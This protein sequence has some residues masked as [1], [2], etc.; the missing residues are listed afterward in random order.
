MQGCVE[1]SHSSFSIVPVYL[2]LTPCMM[3]SFL[4]TRPQEA[5]FVLSLLNP[6][7]EGRPTVDTIV[8]SELLLELHRSIRQRKQAHAGEGQCMDNTESGCGVGLLALK[9]VRYVC[10]GSLLQQGFA[11]PNTC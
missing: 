4:Q 1:V 8:R 6:D 2:V 7:P 9:R 3:W 11:N 5:A 10:T